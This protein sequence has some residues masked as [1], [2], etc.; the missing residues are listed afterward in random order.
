MAHYVKLGEI[1]RKRH[2]RFYK[3]DGGLYAE[4]VFGTKGFSGIASILYHANLPTQVAEYKA[5]GDVRP[6][7]RDEEPL[8]H[9]H[10]KTQ[11]FRAHGDPVSG[12][13]PLLVNEDVSMGLCCPV[14]RMDYFY[15]NGD[16]D[17]LLFVHHGQG[18]LETLFG[19][20][21]YH[22]GDY[23]IIPRGTIYRVV[24]ESAETTM[25]VLNPARVR[26]S[27]RNATATSTGS[28]RNTRP[29]VSGIFV[30]PDNSLSMTRRDAMRC[31][32]K[33]GDG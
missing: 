22:E 2:T 32:S 24:A 29:T 33:H 17:D 4:Q 28:W 27:R 21:P 9:R 6:K 5:L 3:P 10:L 31:A 15:K 16:G 14:E 12:R 20:L 23:L 13:V 8:R 25:L 30:F 26:L 18:H 7:I 1:P 11:N 19:L